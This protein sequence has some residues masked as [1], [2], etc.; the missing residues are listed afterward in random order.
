MGKRV[1]MDPEQPPATSSEASPFRCDLCATAHVPSGGDRP[2]P[3]APARILCLH[4]FR[5][6]AS[7]LRGRMRQLARRLRGVAELV[8]CDAPHTLGVVHVR[9]DREPLR[10]PLASLQ[11][12]PIPRRAWL[13]SKQ[14]EMD[15][16]YLVIRGGEGGGKGEEGK[17]G[18]EGEEA[19]S[20]SSSK[21]RPHQQVIPPRPLHCS[22]GDNQDDADFDKRSVSSAWCDQTEGAAISLAHLIDLWRREGPFAGVLGFSQGA[23][24][25][26][27][28]IAAQ[29]RN[30][31]SLTGTSTVQFAL[32]FSGYLPPPLATEENLASFPLSVP[33]FHATAKEDPVVPPEASRALQECF[34][35]RQRMAVKHR[36]GHSIPGDEAMGREIVAFLERVYHHAESQD[37]RD[38]SQ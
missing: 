5:Q 35:P 17:E 12:P 11:P 29:A 7:T 9:P 30:D 27:A 4:G 14:D 6:R 36:S 21:P 23:G 8:Y 16:G 13:R 24:M 10:V 32:L 33:S 38:H 3:H 34:T 2:L 22:S 20:S 25:A 28:L 15:A 26:T 1:D 19:S 31:P 18:D 37:G